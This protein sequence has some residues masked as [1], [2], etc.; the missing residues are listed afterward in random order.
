M[1]IFLFITLVLGCVK[2]M[3]SMGQSKWEDS[4][5]LLGG[6]S[7]IGLLVWL[8]VWFGWFSGLVF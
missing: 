1:A 2:T 4:A 6:I 3:F 5:S 8:T 7:G